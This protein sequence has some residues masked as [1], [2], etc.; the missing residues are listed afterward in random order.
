MVQSLADLLMR[1]KSSGKRITFWGAGAKGVTFLNTVPGARDIASVVDINVR[2]H[3]SF[4]PGTGQPVVSPESLTAFDPEIVILSNPI[5]VSE[6][7]EILSGLN[8]HP[9]V[10]GGPGSLVQSV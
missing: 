5:Y 4:I 6:I 3:G 7:S 10:I 2:K 8:L 9:A 1:A